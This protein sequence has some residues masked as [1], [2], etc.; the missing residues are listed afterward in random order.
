MWIMVEFRQPK[1]LPLLR[2]ANETSG[3]LLSLCVLV[4]IYDLKRMLF[5]PA[6]EY[7][8]AGTFSLYTFCIVTNPTEP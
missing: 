3:K 1:F 5:P 7:F 6:H 8:L 4:P 2:P